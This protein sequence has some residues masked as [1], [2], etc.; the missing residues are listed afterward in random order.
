MKTITLSN[1]KGGVGKSTTCVVM[2]SGLS[3]GGYKVL[4]VDIDPQCNASLGSGMDIYGMEKS[5]YDV[6]KET[7]SLKE[8][9]RKSDLGFDV[10]TGGLVLAM[11]DMEFVTTGREYLLREALEPVSGDYD[12]CIIDT[13]PSLGILTVNALTASDEVIIPVTADLYPVQGVSQLNWMIQRVRKYSNPKL[14]I[15]G[16][17]ITRYDTTNVTKTLTDEIKKAGDVLGTK[18]FSHPIRN[19]VAVRE[20]QLYKSDLLAE[21]PKANATMDYTDFI[22]EYLKGE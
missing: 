16:I 7:A 19:S 9:I 3:K 18:V 22:D 11:A 2:A 6:F 4:L 5:V 15:S 14:K 12:F 10:A 1:Q 17:L 13:A 21:A 20:S 8:V